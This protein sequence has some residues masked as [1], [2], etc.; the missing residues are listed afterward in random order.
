MSTCSFCTNDSKYK[1]PK[2]SSLYCSI[3]CF[4]S[5]EH[6]AF[7][8]KV[9]EKAPLPD[10]AP[11]VEVELQPFER[12]ANDPVISSMLKQPTLQFH[13]LT[14]LKILTDPKLTNET[15]DGKRTILNIK[16][17]DLRSGGIDENQ[18]VE[19]FIERVVYLSE[20]L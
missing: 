2:C 6:L 13:L 16:L 19:E 10:I 7:D 12:Y 9:S 8:E 18:L 11:K 15:G 3:K 17:N 1:C 14:L 20:N 5:D 4:K